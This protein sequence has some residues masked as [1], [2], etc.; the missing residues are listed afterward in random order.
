MGEDQTVYTHKLTIVTTY[1]H[2][3]VK[4]SLSLIAGTHEEQ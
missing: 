1:V 3:K 4:A 2:G